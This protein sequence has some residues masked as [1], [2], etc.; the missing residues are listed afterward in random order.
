VGF[1]PMSLVFERPNTFHPL[2]CPA[3]KTCEQV[4]KIIEI[5]VIKL[6]LG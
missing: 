2:D 5:T 1:E 4:Q 3:T 6:K